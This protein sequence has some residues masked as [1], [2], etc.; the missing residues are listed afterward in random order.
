MND[1]TLKQKSSEQQLNPVVP[2]AD[3][4]PNRK[5]RRKLQK[6]EKKYHKYLM[7]GL[8]V[9]IGDP[10]LL[11][12]EKSTKKKCDILLIPAFYID[13]VMR[14][15]A[16]IS[17]RGEA[18]A[19]LMRA[20]S[21]ILEHIHES[22]G[23]VYTCENGMQIVFVG[24]LK[25]YP[26]ES[27]ARH[28]VRTAQAFLFGHDHSDLEGGIQMSIQV[29]DFAILT[30][31]DGLSAE[32]SFAGIDVAHVNPEVYT[33]RRTVKMKDKMLT[34]W[35]N[36][37]FIPLKD[38]KKL[39]PKEKTVQPNEFVYFELTE[40]QALSTGLPY[41][42]GKLPSYFTKYIGRCECIGDEWCIQQIRY[43]DDL[44][45]YIRPK[46]VGQA[47]LLESL[48]APVEQ[49]PLIICNG[50]F[51]TGKTF[52][53]VAVALLMTKYNKNPRY[54]QIFVCPRDPHLGEEIGYVKGDETEK[55]MTRAKPII[56][57]ITNF[58]KLR[59]NAEKNGE[60]KG[61]AQIQKDV[62]QIL[63]QYFTFTPLINMGGRS[64]T[65]CFVIYDEAQ[66]FER[67]QAFQLLKR[68]GD[69]SKV[70]LCGDNSQ[71]TNPHLN[72]HSNGLASAA[73]KMEG[74][75][76]AVVINIFDW[77]VVRSAIAIELAR[78]LG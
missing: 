27:T 71:V 26:N 30:G 59:G 52:L 56:D 70:I 33:G 66:D 41:E 23:E 50:T 73:S 21:V 8:D 40:T 51:G 78:R 54:D 5:T 48:L 18:A 77:E 14:F 72:K 2:D 38:F 15:R 67:Y 63:E 47:I 9:L 12:P 46:T 76:Y 16:E 24:I 57:S 60:K 36:N 43:I 62:E 10:D 1:T 55:T 29:S 49:I 31:D 64:L 25:S 3:N 34:Q 22:D 61:Y 53:S 32:A 35:N 39:Y 74:S 75:R 13:R 20:F 28:T 69:G 11:T 58:L 44:P 37:S 6:I 45:P 19:I 4:N 68:I 42:K 65:N 17:N 7:P